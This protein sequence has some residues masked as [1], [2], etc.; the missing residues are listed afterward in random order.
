MAGPDTARGHPWVAISSEWGQEGSP[1]PSPH[2]NRVHCRPGVFS[3][4]EAPEEQRPLK[5]GRQI[6]KISLNVETCRNTGG[7]KKQKYRGAKRYPSY[8]EEQDKGK[9]A[10]RHPEQ[11]RG[12]EIQN[13]PTLCLIDP[14]DSVLG[15]RPSSIFWC[16]SEW[17]RRVE[18]KPGD[19]S[20]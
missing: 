5:V 1:T 12:P 17:G 14:G 19:E 7:L 16:V 18:T 3:E 6:W 9:V 8:K 15:R 4:G 10:E 20:Y 13:H 2:S 11:N